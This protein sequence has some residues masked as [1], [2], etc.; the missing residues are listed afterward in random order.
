ML[1]MFALE[2]LWTLPWQVFEGRG[3]LV[4]ELPLRS[5]D[6]HLPFQHIYPDQ[7]ARHSP[8]ASVIRS[9]PRL[10]RAVHAAERGGGRPLLP[11]VC[12][13]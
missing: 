13:L 4:G 6:F 3:A 7:F 1:V 8:T 2:G 5:C 9:E 10:C 12:L 11:G